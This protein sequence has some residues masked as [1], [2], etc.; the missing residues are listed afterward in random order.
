MG[1]P[2]IKSLPVPRASPGKGFAQIWL[3]AIRAASTERSSQIS[4][5]TATVTASDGEAV[6]CDDENSDYT[7]PAWPE[8]RKEVV[9]RFRGQV[10][11]VE[12]GSAYDTLT[13]SGETGEALLLRRDWLLLMG[14]SDEEVTEALKADVPPLNIQAEQKRLEAAKRLRAAPP[15]YDEFRDL[16][17]RRNSPGG[18]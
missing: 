9:E 11:F 12:G 3:Q 16:L 18:A 4:P 10:R 6:T 1:V 15:S 13:D 14:L 17:R 7:L 5:D 2:V 8:P